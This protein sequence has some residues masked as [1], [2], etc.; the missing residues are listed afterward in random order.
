MTGEAGILTGTSLRAFFKELLGEARE[1]QRLQVDDETEFY[2]VNLLSEYVDPQRVWVRSEDGTLQ[3]EPLA[4]IL[5]R[6]L[7]AHREERAA[8]LRQIGDTSLWV[9]GF[10]SDSLERSLVD[11][12]Y[13]MSM[14]HL[15]YSSLARI[16][17]REPVGGL[18]EELAGKFAGI[19]DLLN[20]V[21]ERVSMTSQ[22]GVVRLYERFL[23]TGSA[24]VAR[25]L[26]AEGVIPPLGRQLREVH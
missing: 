1:R 7:E 3:Q 11:V 2:L 14:G 26:A 17:S 24:R 22:Q 19:V 13:Y 20:E 9:S 10:F 8:A 5:A 25:L 16:K 18:Y 15:A 12:R 6:A 23:K 21:S 4:L